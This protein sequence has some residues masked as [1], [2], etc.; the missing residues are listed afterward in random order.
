VGSENQ[1]VLWPV[2]CYPTLLQWLCEV[3]RYWWELKHGVIH[4]YPEC[5][6]HAQWVTR[7]VSMQSMEEL[8]TFQHSDPCDMGLC[9]IMLQHEVTSLNC[10]PIRRHSSCLPSAQYSL[11]Y[12][13]LYYATSY[14]TISYYA[15]MSGEYAFHGRTGTFSASRNCVQILGAVHYH[16]ET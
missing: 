9:I 8:E 3:A 14:Y 5:C 4:V 1:S 11:N 7:L 6:K 13:L 15:I 2:E 16:Y 12:S 10:S